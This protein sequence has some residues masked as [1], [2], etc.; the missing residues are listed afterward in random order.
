MLHAHRSHSTLMLTLHACST[1][2]INAHAL[3]ST[4]TPN[5]PCLEF[6]SPHS[7]P[8]TSRSTLMLHAHAPCSPS[9]LTLHA[10][11]KLQSLHSKLSIL[12]SC[13]VYTSNSFIYLRWSFLT[14]KWPNCCRRQQRGPQGPS[15]R[16]LCGR[17]PCSQLV[18]IKKIRD[19]LEVLFNFKNF[20]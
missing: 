15:A 13:F 5:A 12:H 16:W 19:N 1:L 2:T 3:Q 10:H 18:Y 20:N 14:S 11:I 6:L 17:R 9:M 8:H 7:T 4:L